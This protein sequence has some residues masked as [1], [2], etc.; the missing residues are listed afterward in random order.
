MT[1]GFEIRRGIVAEHGEVESG[2]ALEGSVATAVVAAVLGEDGRDV[3]FETEGAAL[4]ARI[5]LD[6]G[7]GGERADL[8]GQLGAAWELGFDHAAGAGLDGGALRREGGF[9]GEIADG[10]VLI[11]TGDDDGLGGVGLGE[12]E[13]PGLDAD[14]AECGAGERRER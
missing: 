9:A 3:A 2:L 13:G 11:D 1:Y 6:V 8:G 7:L 4:A 12:R 5:D 14:L 10:A